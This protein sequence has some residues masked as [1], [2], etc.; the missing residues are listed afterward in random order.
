MQTICN[1]HAITQLKDQTESRDQRRTLDR[2]QVRFATAIYPRVSL[3]NHSCDPNVV[4]SFK[5]DSNVIVVKA[6]REIEKAGEIFNCYGPHH[7]KMSLSERQQS[8][9][10]QYRF[11]CECTACERQKSSTGLTGLKCLKCKSSITQS[12]NREI[13]CKACSNTT[14]LSEYVRLVDNLIIQMDY[15]LSDMHKIP[16]RDLVKKTLSLITDFKVYLAVGNQDQL[17]LASINDNFKPFYLRYSKLV[18]FLA[19]NYC[20]LSLFDK[21]AGLIEENIRLLQGLYNFK[22][23]RSDQE[24][25]GIE[26]AHELFKL[27]E[28]QCNCQRFSH[29]L[30]N[31]NKAIEIASSFYSG[32]NKVL[33]E[34]NQ[35][36]SDI[37][38]ILQ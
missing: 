8:L 37:L 21:A 14:P 12:D 18:D 3:L 22:D 20:D 6:G 35:L 4:S 2:D 36:K 34:F 17:D 1:A 29:A 28:I 23:G 25:Y 38:S 24:E 9:W 7:V 32:D 11:K 15:L 27:A 5:T 26:I 33:Q 10:E 13:T 19:R 30:V 16:Q 31:V